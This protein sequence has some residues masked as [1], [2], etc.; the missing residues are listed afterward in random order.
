MSGIQSIAARENSWQLRCRRTLCKFFMKSV[1]SHFMDQ[2]QMITKD[3][4]IPTHTKLCPDR[5]SVILIALQTFKRHHG[6][7]LVPYSFICPNNSSWPMETW[8]LPLGMRVNSIRKG[9]SYIHNIE[10]R[11][12]LDSIGFVWKV[13]EF[14]FQ[15]LLKVLN[16]YKNQ[17]GNVNNMPLDFIIPNDTT[18]WPEEAVGLKLGHR[19]QSIQ[20]GQLKLYTSSKEYSEPLSS[21]GLIT[22]KR[23]SSL[24]TVTANSSQN[25]IMI[26]VIK[27]RSQYKIQSEADILEILV[28]YRL[29]YG[30]MRIPAHSF[31]VPYNDSSWPAK[32]WGVDIGAQL[33][34]IRDNDRDRDRDKDSGRRRRRRQRESI[35]ML[36]Q[37]VD[38]M[39]EATNTATTTTGTVTCGTST[40]RAAVVVTTGV[41]LDNEMEGEEKENGID[42]NET[43]M[44]RLANI[45]TSTALKFELVYL[46][47]K[48]YLQKYGTVLV[49][50]SFV[51]PSDGTETNTELVRV[52]TGTAT[53]VATT[54]TTSNIAATSAT[55]TTTTSVTTAAAKECTDNSHSHWPVVLRGL[56]LG[57]EVRVL[58]KNK[59]FR[60]PPYSLRLD[61]LGFVWDIKSHS[62]ANIVA[63]LQIYKR[64][65][66]TLDVPVDFI[67]PSSSSSSTNLSSS[68][69]STSSTTSVLWPRASWGIPLGAQ[70]QRLKYGRIQ[71]T[72][73]DRIKLDRL[74]HFMWGGNS[75]EKFENICIALRCHYELFGDYFVPRYFI[76]PSEEPWPESTRGLHLGNR[77]RNIRFRTA[78]NEEKYHKILREMKFPLDYHGKGWSRISDY[79]DDNIYN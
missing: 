31:I 65:Y 3:T 40:S 29:K 62:S 49:P 10:N 51:V 6:H 20:Q 23:N 35:Q 39:N 70:V 61:A 1:H 55:S 18:T 59:T 53:S 46:A 52:T 21:L 37:S 7:L 11:N 50:A 16:I 71:L 57:H 72:E 32:M 19:V 79:P 36:Q 41:V 43:V 56:R 38:T 33:A 75:D 73:S 48:L 27:S 24:N 4:T 25:E 77:I 2:Y 44:S 42:N 74:G 69:L 14:K 78:Y 5:F 22:K 9:E 45:H 63:L 30:H 8:H 60:Q 34:D 28:I 17:F 47:L 15:T 26:A 12:A 54:S 13:N 67:I 66:K 64:I 76:V 68:T 58:R